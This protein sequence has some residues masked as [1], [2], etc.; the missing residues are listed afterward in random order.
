MGGL[1]AIHCCPHTAC[2]LQPGGKMM[3]RKLKSGLGLRP[4]QSVKSDEG[5]WGTACTPLHVV[6]MPANFELEAIAA[7]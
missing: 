1:A 6:Y 7:S 5:Y 4:R 2:A 3:R